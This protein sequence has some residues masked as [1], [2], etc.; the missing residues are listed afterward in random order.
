MII[1]QR[2]KDEKYFER[3][4][5]KK[6]SQWKRRMVSMKR[7]QTREKMRYQR[8]RKPG[9]NDNLIICDIPIDSGL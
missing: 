9:D 5:I 2:E 6:I 8:K 1:N 4:N 7:M 3:R